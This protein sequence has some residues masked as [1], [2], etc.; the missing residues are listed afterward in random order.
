MLK[1]VAIISILFLMG[2]STQSPKPDSQKPQIPTGGVE[3]KLNIDYDRLQSHLKMDREVESLGFVEKPFPT[4]EVGYG[5]P[6]NRNCR[7]DHFVLIHFQLLCRSTNADTYYGAIDSYDM[8]PLKGRT[9]RW[10]LSRAS[11]VVNLDDKGYGQIK[12]TA[13]S[14]QKYQRLKLAVGN[15][16]L[17]IKAGDMRQIVTPPN[18]CN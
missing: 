16:N 4:C 7:N 1:I 14:S 13:R 8:R 18:W 6:S 15:D 10:N 9:V 5:Y 11:G 3:Q 2:C 17:R 12:T